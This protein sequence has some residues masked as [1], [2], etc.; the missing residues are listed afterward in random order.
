MKGIRRAALIASVLLWLAS[1]CE[2]ADTPPEG[3]TP[4]PTVPPR[5]K[6]AQRLGAPERYEASYRSDTGVSVI[7]VNADVYV[8]DAYAV[9]IIE[10]VPRPFYDEEVLAFIERHREGLVWTDQKTKKEYD[11]HGFEIDS[12]FTGSDIGFTMHSLW[13][14]NKD[15]FY[16]NDGDYYSIHAHYGIDN[17]TGKLAWEPQLEYIKS[18][19]N[20]GITDLMPLTDGRAEGCTIT[21]EEARAFAD[22]EAHALSADYEMTGCGQL[23]VMETVGNPRYYYIF[24]YTRHLGGI[25]V[26]DHYG[27]ESCDNEYDFTSGLGVITIIVNDEG[28]CFVRY[29]NPYDVGEVIERDCELLSFDEIMD[30]FSRVGL[31]SIQHLERYPDLKENTLEVYRIAFGYMAVRQPDDVDAYYYVPVWDFYGHRVLYGTGGYA[32]G[33]EFGKIWGCSELTINAIDGTVIDRRY[34]Y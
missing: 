30:I 21:L 16:N 7:T 15:E 27:G 9:D 8:P 6:L 3:V 31:L 4:S 13:V 2:P 18:R 34:G 25:P 29:S 5:Q 14:Y 32:H 28:V 33:K 24:R 23:P 22:A 19:F 12:A 10:A 17:R 20:L 1:G 11:G 26:S